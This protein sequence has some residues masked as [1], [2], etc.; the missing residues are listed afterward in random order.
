MDRLLAFSYLSAF[1]GLAIGCLSPLAGISKSDDEGQPD[2]S[3]KNIK[4]ADGITPHR[5]FD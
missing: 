5:L 3:V 1:G 2:Y 4:K